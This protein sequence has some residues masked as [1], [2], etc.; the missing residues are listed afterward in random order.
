MSLPEGYSV[1][2]ATEGDLAAMA[3]LADAYDVADLGEPDTAPEH[4]ADTWRVAGFDAERDAWLVVAPDG[5]LAAFG[6]VE[7]TP[8]EVLESFGRVHPQHRGLGLGTFLVASMEARAA[9][10]PGPT[11]LH[12]AVTATD[13]AARALLEGRGLELVRFFWHME[14]ELGGSDATASPAPDGLIIRAADED[15][16]RPAW[17]AIDEA[18][19]DDWSWETEPFEEWI[20]FLQGG[21]EHLVVA[22]EGSEVAGAVT[23][24]S[25]GE[26][27]WIGELGV[28]PAWRGRG[29]GLALLRHAFGVL[30]ELGV[31]TARLNVDADNE[32]GAT[33]LYERA[34]MRVRRE[35]LV[36]EK[37]WEAG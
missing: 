16:E 20:A 3:A 23:F 13:V 7:P 9:E 29:L 37:R 35:W 11:R 15:D 30:A 17:Q 8:G 6:L 25:M 24:R 5:E 36:Y 27:G 31:A 28:R 18:F 4:L 14:R 34:G 2:P 21:G 19:A 1:R 26:M 10:R 33:R 32:T 22:V 12:N